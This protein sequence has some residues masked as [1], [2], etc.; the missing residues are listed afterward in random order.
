M[1]KIG[2]FGGAFDPFH[3]GHMAICRAA[4]EQLGLNK[5]I[6]IP[7]WKAPHKQSFTTSFE[8]RLAMVRLALAGTGWEVSCYERD[9]GGVSYSAETVED[10]SR[11]YPDDELFFIIGGDSYR[12]F[13]TWYQPWRITAAAT[14]AVYPRKGSNI[15]VTPPA[16]IFMADEVEVSSTMLR[17][18]LA[19][20]EDINALVPKAVGEYIE[21]HN[22][23]K[24]GVL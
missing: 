3:N 11:E 1:S 13:N 21:K 9:R 24:R 5:L 4:A 22:L 8:D 7:T 20:G 17:E 18:K 12:D 10:F 14:L 2:L 15:R 6:V 16:T 19:R 23:Y